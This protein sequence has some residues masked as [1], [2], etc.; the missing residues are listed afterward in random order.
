MVEGAKLFGAA[1]LRGVRGRG[2]ERDGDVAGVDFLL[3]FGAPDCAA[4]DALR[5]EPGVEAGGQ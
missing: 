5:V 1:D 3:D 4:R 2:Q